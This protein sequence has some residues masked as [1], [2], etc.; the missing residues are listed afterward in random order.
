MLQQ[1]TDV[2]CLDRC[3]WRDLF[4]EIEE[5]TKKGGSK[6]SERST[7]DPLPKNMMTLVEA[8]LPS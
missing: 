1:C 6:I 5:K 2:D 7:T 8:T 3:P 4:Q